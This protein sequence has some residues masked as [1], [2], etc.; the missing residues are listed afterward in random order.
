MATSGR[1]QEINPQSSRR[2][3]REQMLDAVPKL[4]RCIGELERMGVESIRGHFDPNM[5]VRGLENSINNTMAEVFEPTSPEYRIYRARLMPV[6]FTNDEE[7]VREDFRKRNE[8][9][10]AKLQELLEIF[11]KQ[12]AAKPKIT[13]PGAEISGVVSHLSKPDSDDG[14]RMQLLPQTGRI[15]IISKTNISEA[16]IVSE[17][18]DKLDL[19]P[20]LVSW[21]TGKVPLAEALEPL[22]EADF[23]LL[24]FDS[25]N[26]P[27][28]PSDT[29]DEVSHID[30]DALVVLGY[31]V[32][33]LGEENVC[34][35]H[36]PGIS[37]SFPGSLFESI[38]YDARGAWQLELA[39]LMK[40]VGILFDMNKVL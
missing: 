14:E 18:L 19:S 20:L 16:E 7:Q 35:I 9:T 15:V 36:N 22:E 3:T 11:K 5:N 37:L 13:K 40:T 21:P 8:Q 2:L 38:R 27:F 17:F 10:R 25:P 31:L 39:R 26:K 12:S 4:E 28:T 33:R 29:I 23:A 32:G 30:G 34:V 1:H 6:L 24:F